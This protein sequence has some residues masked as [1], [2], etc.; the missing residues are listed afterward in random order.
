MADANKKDEIDKVVGLELGADDYLTKP[1]GQRELL[2]RIKAV[3]RR[4]RI[5]ELGGAGKLVLPNLSIDFASR[6][7]TKGSKKSNLLQPSLTFC[8]V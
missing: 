2:A 3:L 1:F 4:S 8:N 7:V 6:T 5:P